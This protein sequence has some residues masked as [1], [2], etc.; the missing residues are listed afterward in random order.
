MRASDLALADDPQPRSGRQAERS[1]VE[2]KR[3]FAH[4]K[5][6]CALVLCLALAP[7][8]SGCAAKK[9]ERAAATE[10]LKQA[11]NG[12]CPGVEGLIRLAGDGSS[13]GSLY[14][15]SL[16]EVGP[17]YGCNAR[18]LEARRLLEQAA[19]GYAAKARTQGRPASE[20]NAQGRGQQDTLELESLAA[21]HLLASRILLRH[22]QPGLAA[23]HLQYLVDLDAGDCGS[24]AAQLLRSVPAN[25]RAA[26]RAAGPTPSEPLRVRACL[27]FDERA[28]PSALF[29]AA[30]A[31]KCDALET[32]AEVASAREQP[33]QS[34]S[35]AAAAGVH[36]AALWELGRI[37]RCDPADNQLVQLY[38]VA[39]RDFPI[40]HF[41]RGLAYLRLGNGSMAEAS[42]R[43]AANSSCEPCAHRAMVKL[44]QIHEA[45]TAGLQVSPALSAHWY[46]M[47]S[48]AGDV[49]AR[50]RL[51]ERLLA[52][53]G[54]SQD[55][56]RALRLLDLAASR[57]SLEARL[58]LFR[59]ADGGRAAGTQV[60]PEIAAKWLGSA[61]LLDR[62][63]V[64]AFEA[65]L[66]QLSE[67]AQD[68]VR[69]EVDRFA[70][71]TQ[72]VWQP[73]NYDEPL[74]PT[75]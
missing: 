26:R 68:T 15:A 48:E 31:G 13:H 65:Y 12:E 67:A 49:H 22:S 21:A 64:P 18:A 19:V 23:P 47:A 75:S 39:A 50:V 6:L 2:V 73:V 60:Q 34:S 70:T 30:L 45:G 53:V 16:Y 8:L 38:R 4:P 10:F 71:A 1:V 24:Q 33:H 61:A 63:L 44:A 58:L 56:P 52:G 28:G 37:S 72:R 51:A 35:V 25:A 62:S 3:W 43:T 46:F 57:G 17:Q 20:P 7:V 14:L 74:S 5:H 66:G 40:A 29:Q 55:V 41:N 36:L 69:M 42:L 32:L 9:G 59:L 27:E 54:V 11:R